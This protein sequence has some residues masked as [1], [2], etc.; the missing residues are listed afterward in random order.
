MSR[1]RC[2]SVSGSINA[3]SG[4]RRHAAASATT[5]SSKAVSGSQRDRSTLRTRSSIC[6]GA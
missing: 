2:A 5:T 4:V 3:P 6:I 1:I